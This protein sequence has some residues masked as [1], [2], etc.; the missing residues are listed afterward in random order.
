MLELGHLRHSE[1][2]PSDDE[3]GLRDTASPSN[4][5]RSRSRSSS[6][7]EEEGEAKDSD[8]RPLLASH[9]D[10]AGHGYGHDDDDGVVGWGRLLHTARLEKL[11]E[12]WRYFRQPRT[13][14]EVRI[15]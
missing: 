5:T 7:D 15:T 10:G 11:K 13:N 14:A 2:V 1:D 4:Q 12:Y 3:F 9:S 6:G 8:R